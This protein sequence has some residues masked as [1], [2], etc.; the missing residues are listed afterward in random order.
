VVIFKSPPSNKE[1]LPS[2]TKAQDVEGPE[3]KRG[4]PRKNPRLKSKEPVRVNL[5]IAQRAPPSRHQKHLALNARV[6]NEENPSKSGSTCPQSFKE[7]MVSKEKH[8]WLEAVFDEGIALVE[9]GTF[10]EVSEVPLKEKLM[11][12]RWV[13]TKKSDSRFKARLV[14][15]GFEQRYGIHYTKTYAPVVNLKTVRILLALAAHFDLE[16]QQSDVRTAFLNALLPPS[17]RVYMRIPEGWK[18]MNDD[19]IALLLIKSLYGLKQAPKLWYEE[20]H[21]TLT[22]EDCPVRLER[23]V[24]DECLYI[25]SDMAI[26]V[27]VDDTLYL[28]SSIEAISKVKAFLSARYEMR[29]L[30]DAKNFLGIRVSRDRANCQ[31]RIDQQEYC[32]GIVKLW[33]MENTKRDTP[34]TPGCKLGKSVFEGQD[35]LPVVTEEDLRIYKGMLG[36]LQYSAMATRPD[37]AYKVGNSTLHASP[38]YP[39]QQGDSHKS[40]LR[41]HHQNNIG[42]NFSN[43]MATSASIQ[44]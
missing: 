18:T 1:K 2:S 15:R 27:Y 31:L 25:G 12:S 19:T 22:S 26:A 42:T 16:L 23:S 29:D 32:E 4:Q 13:F 3:R 43:H 36:S 7:A 14:I 39:L 28:S 21:Q 44:I 10:V 37:I 8:Q 40:Q 9:S 20:L 17:E 34:M 38:T 41:T 33:G 5:A 35:A 30:G 24:F 11:G 6:P